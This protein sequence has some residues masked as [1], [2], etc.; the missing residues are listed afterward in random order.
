MLQW[1]GGEVDVDY[2]IDLTRVPELDGIESD[3]GKVRIGAMASL[4][5]LDH[6]S[7]MNQLMEVLAYTARLMCTK[8]TRTIGTVG[9][10]M[11]N[12]SPGADLSPLF[13]AL[14][15]S[16]V[17]LGAK[18]RRTVSMEN[19]FTGVNKTVLRDEELLYEIIV[20]VPDERQRREASY[21]RVAR[22][23]VDIALV[24]AAVSVTESE[25]E[26]CGTRISLGSVAPVPIRALE[27]ERVLVGHDLVAIDEGL[28]AEA[29]SLAAGAAEPISDVRAGAQYRRKMCAVLT[30]R[31]LADSL[32]RLNGTG[33]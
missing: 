10:N 21:K 4:D 3:D 27:A 24:S 32:D 22:T 1:R 5:A 28:L 25:G 29:G 8:Q 23:V 20:P 14:D 12:A 18:G 16:A 26:V 6:A 15:A 11:C 33:R 19:F 7:G 31:A 30:R 9:G 2:C 17:I 13:V